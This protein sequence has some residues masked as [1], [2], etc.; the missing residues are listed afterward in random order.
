M[1]ENVVWNASGIVVKGDE[2]NVSWNTIFDGADISPSKPYHDRPRYQDHLSILGNASVASMKI[3]AG[4]KAYDPSANANARNGG[5]L[6][7]R[8]TGTSQHTAAV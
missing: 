6:E 4:T 7:K 5:P 3:G 1:T 2:H 8:T